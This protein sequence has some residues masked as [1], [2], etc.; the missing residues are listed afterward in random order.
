MQ[1]TCRT[2]CL[3]DSPKSTKRQIKSISKELIKEIKGFE[4]RANGIL[5][6]RNINDSLNRT[7]RK[8]NIELSIDRKHRMLTDR[9]K[10]PAGLETPK[11]LL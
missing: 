7:E 10:E 1:L 5:Q 6:S 9:R 3:N 4:S 8:I 11:A 2:T